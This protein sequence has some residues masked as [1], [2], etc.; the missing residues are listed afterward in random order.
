MSRQISRPDVTEFVKCP[1]CNLD[2]V[3]DRPEHKCGHDLKSEEYV[4]EE[5]QVRLLWTPDFGWRSYE[6][7][8]G[9]VMEDLPFFAVFNWINTHDGFMPVNPEDYE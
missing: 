4:S 3:L 8:G 5:I 2:I 1:L 6:L 9:D 7:E